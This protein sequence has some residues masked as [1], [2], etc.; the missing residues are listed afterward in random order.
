MLKPLYG[1]TGGDARRTLTIGQGGID[2]LFGGAG[3]DRLYGGNDGDI[4]D[5]GSGN[6]VLNGQGGFDLIFSDAGNDILIGGKDGDTFIF[7]NGFGQD[8]IADFDPS[9]SYEYIDLSAVT[10]II[11]YRDLKANHMHQSGTDTIIDAGGGNVITLTNIDM[12]DLTSADF[13]FKGYWNYLSPLKL[14]HS[15]LDIGAMKDGTGLGC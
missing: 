1:P 15:L 9:Q 8:R 11:D 12:T 2:K 3:N 10:S 5:G 13:I 4:L 14:C 7:R 6:D